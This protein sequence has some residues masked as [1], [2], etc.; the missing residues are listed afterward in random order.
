MVLG[1]A[2]GLAA[3]PS[4]WDF[5][6][7]FVIGVVAGLGAALAVAGLLESRRT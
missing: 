2:T 5:I 3:F 4:P 6:A 7:G 1:S